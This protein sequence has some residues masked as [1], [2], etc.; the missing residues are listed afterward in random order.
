VDVSTESGNAGSP[1]ETATK[2][3]PL[4]ELVVC[5]LEPWDEIWRRNQFFVDALLRVNPTLRVL[6]VEPPAD[7]LFDLTKRRRPSLPR[8]RALVDGRLRLFRPLKPLPRRLGALTDELLFRQVRL[9]VRVVGFVRPA[10]WINDVTYAPLISRTGWPSLYDVTDDWL[11][12]PFEPRELQRLHR[13]DA[14]A[15][16][17]ADEVVVCSPTLAQSRGTTR[18]VSLVPNGVDVE[19]FR[20]PW[21]R[22]SDLPTAPTAVYVGSLHDARLDVELV[23]NLADVLPRLN[24]VLVGPDSLGAESRHLLGCRPSVHLL[25][26]RP[27]SDV[28]AYLQHADVVIVPHRVSPFTESLDPIKAYE[29]LAIRTPTVATPVAG[30]REHAAALQIADREDFPERVLEALSS[31]IQGSRA[32]C[33]GW[34][35]RAHGFEDVL[36]RAIRRDL[37]DHGGDS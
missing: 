2:V 18:P 11:L 31:P 1:Q 25:G 6:F 34:D 20:R 16:A 35:V 37:D 5:S 14:M 15:L 12:A 22:P 21:P 17:Q 10:L 27:Y 26:A 4:R 28:P 13:L 9:A 29:C 23:A 7:V 32:E 8:F 33:V 24:V 19:H 3:P 30:F 36:V